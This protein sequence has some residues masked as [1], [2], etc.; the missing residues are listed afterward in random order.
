MQRLAQQ[1]MEKIDRTR[2]VAGTIMDSL[3][4]DASLSSFIPHHDK[5]TELGFGSDQLDWLSSSETFPRTVQLLGL[6][7]YR[8]A[9]LTGLVVSVGGLTESLV[10]YSSSSLLEYLGVLEEG[11]LAEFGNEILNVFKRNQGTSR[12]TIP[13]LKCLDLLFCHGTLEEI[14]ANGELPFA[15]SLLDLCKTEITKCSDVKKLNCAV[16]V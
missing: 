16:D 4:A 9:A 6:A 3:C 11:E 1:A 7:T 5:L 8:H 12:I 10:K 13:T 14:L 2:A 15:Q